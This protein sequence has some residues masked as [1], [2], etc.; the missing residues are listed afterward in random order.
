MVII[1]MGVSGS[2]KTT[3]G[4][5]LAQDLVWP[6][7]DGDDFHPQANIN[8]M[9]RGIPLTDDDRDAWLTV[10]RQWI[11]TLI[12]TRRSAV[13][14]CSALKQTYRDRLQRP[15]V[16]FVYLKGDRALI[17]QRLLARQGH[18]MP[19]DLL[20]SQFATLEEPQGVPVIDIAQAP[21]TIVAVIKR[22]LEFE[23]NGAL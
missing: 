4:R 11:D 22:T 6:F 2:G 7:Y 10:L 19:A 13:L 16:H 17:R 15:E 20:A 3:I 23:Q 9:R 1:L 21:E 8:K 5:L 12:D 14:A 18:F